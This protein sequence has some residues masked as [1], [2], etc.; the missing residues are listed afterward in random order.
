M[1]ESKLSGIRSSGAALQVALAYYD[2]WTHKDVEKTMSYVAKDIVCDAP[3]GR[4]E[5]TAQ[6]RKFWADF[7]QM[8][9]GSHLVAA[10]GDDATALILYDSETIPVKHAPVAEYVTV[11]NGKI[12]YSRMVFDRTPFANLQGGPQARLTAAQSQS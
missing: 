7:L 9:T 6:F 12:A 8:L 5:G 2:A 1:S 3:G 10:Y 11:E 4:I